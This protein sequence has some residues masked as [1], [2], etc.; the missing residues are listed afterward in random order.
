MSFSQEK[1]EGFKPVP[2]G[3]YRV[4]LVEFKP[5]MAKSGNSVNLNANAVII[6]HPEWE[7]ERKVIANLN[8]SIENFIQD[9]SH[10]FGLPMEVQP[11]GKLSLP[12][13]WDGD[14]SKPETWKYNGPLINKEAEWELGPPAEGFSFNTIRK[15][16]CRIPDCA[17]KYPKIQHANDMA[18]NSN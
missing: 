13:S 3:V 6:G 11:D 10:S 7:K 18:K 9:F 15:F 12:G 5:K 2:S 14:E 16:I 17:Q 4:R 8:T 1:L